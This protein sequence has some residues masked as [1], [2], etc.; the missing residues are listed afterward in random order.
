MKKIF[1]LFVCFCLM[2]VCV[3]GFSACKSG[4]ASL[5]NKT[6]KFKFD[7]EGVFEKKQ[8]FEDCELSALGAKTNEQ[9]LEYFFTEGVIDWSKLGMPMSSS[10]E[11]FKTWLIENLAPSD[12]EI[13]KVKFSSEEKATLTYNDVKYDVEMDDSH[14]TE[15]YMYLKIYEKGAEKTDENVIG[16]V[17][18]GSWDYGRKGKITKHNIQ[19]N[20]DGVLS[21][22]KTVS[23]PLAFRQGENMPTKINLV[24][25]GNWKFV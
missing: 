14:S 12:D 21:S 9:W 24:F 7:I 17:N 18:P 3:F 8:S 5:A 25:D 19:I 22:E 2:F 13:G 16:S 15:H 11:S 4:R 23:V 10:F 20:I 1:K 6:M